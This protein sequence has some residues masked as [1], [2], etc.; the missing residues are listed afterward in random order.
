MNSVD[1]LATY[2]DK[3]LY[4]KD[5][6]LYFDFGFLTK[7]LIAPPL[8][9]LTSTKEEEIEFEIDEEHLI[10]Y[11]GTVISENYILHVTGNPND[12][13][14]QARP[15]C[16]NM[17]DAHE[18][19]FRF[20]FLLDCS[21][22]MD[23]GFAEFRAYIKNFI[24]R[25]AQNKKFQNSI[26]QIRPFSTT[27]M[28]T[29]EFKVSDLKD[30]GSMEFALNNLAAEGETELDNALC[31]TL[32]EIESDNSI[33]TDDIIFVWTD[34]KDSTGGE[35]AAKLQVYAEALQQKS[36]P[37]KI[38]AIGF[39]SDCDE[40]KLKNLASITG[41]DY[42][43]LREG[44]AELSKIHQ[45]LQ[46]DVISK[47]RKLIHFL[48]SIHAVDK[49]FTVKAP[50]GQIS[51]ANDTI[52]VPGN[53]IVNGISYNVGKGSP[54]LIPVCTEEKVVASVQPVEAVDLNNLDTLISTL[55]Q[56]Q[57]YM[58]AQLLPKF[59]QFSAAPT[60]AVASNLKTDEHQTKFTP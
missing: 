3:I 2:I 8:K 16:F 26:I 54:H 19:N 9:V 60:S 30:F 36:N 50:Q 39:G 10:S 42:I 17:A 44:V 12:A 5:D 11:L 25:I 23:K 35:N 1:S 4:I 24:K 59:G 7:C 45:Y 51:V 38:F 37:P 53:V 58:L 32:K 41:T 47:P 55:N 29:E 21:G 22:S 18:V 57:R 33:L 28:P 40:T 20:S 31:T 34:G 6:F 46:L 43:D 52:T 15:I 14:Q 13:T 49:K 27:L 56:Q 48:Q